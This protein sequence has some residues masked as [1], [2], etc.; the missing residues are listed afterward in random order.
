MEER[1]REFIEFW[2]NQ[3]QEEEENVYREMK[4]SL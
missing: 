4:M 2:N 3:Q 1:E